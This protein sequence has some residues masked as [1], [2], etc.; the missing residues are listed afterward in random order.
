MKERFVNFLL[1]C[2]LY[3]SGVAIMI[4]FFSFL[5]LIAPKG[6]GFPLVGLIGIGG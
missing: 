3:L 4:M 2:A 5:Y 1:D 6:C